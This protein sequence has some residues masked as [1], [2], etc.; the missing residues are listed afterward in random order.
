MVGVAVIYLQRVR[1]LQRAPMPNEPT[2]FDPA[3]GVRFLGTARVDGRGAAWPHGELIADRDHLM[4]RVGSGRWGSQDLVIDRGQVRAITVEGSK[5]SRRVT[6]VATGPER[7]RIADARF[8]AALADPAPA[9]TDLGW[10][11]ER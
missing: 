5:L 4:V 10:P 11:V 3:V 6:I 9:L 8:G 7:Q 2:S 1:A